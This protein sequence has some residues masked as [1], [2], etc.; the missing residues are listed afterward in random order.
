[1]ED[2]K[3]TA[4]KAQYAWLK[5]ELDAAFSAVMGS[6]DFTG[7]S[8][9]AQ[10]AR[11]LENVLQVNIAVP[12]ASGT[13]ALV[14]AL[15]ALQLPA[16]AEVI[17]PAFADASLVKLLLGMGLIP[18]L[19]DVQPGTFTLDAAS[20]IAAITSAT[21]AILP[22]HLFGQ[23]AAMAEL[24]EVATKYK[25]WLLEDATQ[26]FGAVYTWPNGRSQSAGSLGHAAATAF[27]PAK[28]LLGEGEGAALLL[29]YPELA[30]TF[31]LDMLHSLP[32]LDGDAPELNALQAVMLEVKVKYIET[33]NAARQQ[34]AAYYNKAFAQMPQVQ[35][36]QRVP[37][38][39][40]TYQ[41]Y[42]ITVAPELRDALQAHLRTHF[43]PSIV[44]Y[45]QPLHLQA[46]FTE[47][48]NKQGDFPMAERL[49]QSIL[50]LPMH[51]ELKE[52]QLQ[53]ICD[54]IQAF[55]A[56]V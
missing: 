23:C 39:T 35:A 42:A 9:V 32:A 47:S 12:C 48:K 46:A 30:S 14:L 37:Y 22:V 33:F 51:S 17:L 16:G 8:Q 19:A 26:A 43:I 54:N 2:I 18:V 28:P 31:G 27:Y 44:Y 56:Q 10:L 24:L 4:Q 5:P 55:F 40:H 13:A 41:Q 21:A 7:S 6:M 36:P 3:M 20:V 34:I 52:E 15:K 49:S 38:S 11:Q 29:N 25:L 53:Y 50:S 1:M 45:P